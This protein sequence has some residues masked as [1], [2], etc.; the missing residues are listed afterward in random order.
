VFLC[1]EI[2]FQKNVQITQEEVREY[3]GVPPRR[4]T[5]ILKSKEVR[6]LHQS[7]EPQEP[8]PRAQHRCITRQQTR[9]IYDYLTDES[10]PARQRCKP[11]ADVFL[12]AT[13]DVLPQTLH[14][15][16]FGYRDLE[17]KTI[18]IYCKQDEGIGSFNREEEKE[19][20]RAQAT[21]RT[22]RIDKQLPK[23]PHSA[24]WKDCAYC[25]KFHFG[26]QQEDT[27][28]WSQSRTALEV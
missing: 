25:D 24:D 18:Q 17:P 3:T 14:H 5:E 13:G 7:L 12:A 27:R 11:W 23:R 4:Q 2:A 15:K 20:T 1:K 22:N 6:M 28:F 9:A 19:L 21:N 26:V 16:P 10:I 8:D